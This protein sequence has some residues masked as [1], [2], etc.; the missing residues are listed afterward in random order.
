MDSETD[1]LLNVLLA[2]SSRSTI[3]K[4]GKIPTIAYE[5]VIANTDDNEHPLPHN[6]AETEGD[7]ARGV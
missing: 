4:V 3:A 2:T 1:Q 6:G 7:N 5:K